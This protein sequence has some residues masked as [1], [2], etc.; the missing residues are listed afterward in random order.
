M[1]LTTIVL[2]MIIAIVAT[3]LI[4]AIVGG[5]SF[6]VAFSD[7]IIFGLIVFLIIKLLMKK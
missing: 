6:I 3:M 4:S 5:I 7:V 1:I 2:L